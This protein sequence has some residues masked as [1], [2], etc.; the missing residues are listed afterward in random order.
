[1]EWVGGWFEEEEE[2][3]GS[4]GELMFGVGGWVGRTAWRW[5]DRGEK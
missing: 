1:M 2:E 5:V 3:E 4:S